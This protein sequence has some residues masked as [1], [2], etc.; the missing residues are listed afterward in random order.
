MEWHNI[1]EEDGT[2][3]NFLYPFIDVYPR[4]FQQR[5]GFVPRVAMELKKDHVRYYLHDSFVK[6]MPKLY[7]WLAEK[8]NFKTLEQNVCQE[9]ERMHRQSDA[10]TEKNLKTRTDAQLTQEATT[11]SNSLCSLIGWG[12]LPPLIDFAGE[13][14]SKAALFAIETQIQKRSL[15]THA[16]EYFV[17]L[18]TP[19]DDT[20]TR[21]EERSFLELASDF[22]KE[23]VPEGISFAEF[24]KKF[25]DLHQRTQRHAERFVWTY[26]GYCGPALTIEKT[27]E[28]AREMSQRNDVEKQL[29]QQAQNLDELRKKQ[30]QFEREL[31]LDEDQSWR[32]HVARESVRLKTV[33]KDAMVHC[34]YA[35][36]AILRETARRTG[37]ALNLLRCAKSDELDQVLKKTL[38]EDDL[39]QRHECVIYLSGEKDTA[40]LQG[41]AASAFSKTEFKELDVSNE[42][43]LTGQCAQPGFASG[44]A[45]IID[46]AGQMEKMRDGDILVSIATVPEIVPAMKKAAAIVTEIGGITSHAAIVSRELGIPCLIGTK[47][48]TKWLK[49]G[50]RIEVDATHGIVRKLGR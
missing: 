48:A 41:A 15:S 7:R 4:H 16:S 40:L 8:D 44:Y 27:F 13:H 14:I 37:I 38:S 49:D 33:R 25:P 10:V 2:S 5:F 26:F 17:T 12:L 32:V 31:G 20:L 30:K 21:Q 19:T 39:R 28:K 24:K 50:D 46:K 9:S 34:A 11:L 45:K 22:Q 18:T 1:N 6:K 29:R 47:V 43:H 35:L 3:L 36:D 42:N 23:A